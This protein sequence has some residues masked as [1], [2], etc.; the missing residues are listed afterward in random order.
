MR[1]LTFW[2]LGILAGTIF[3]IVMLFAPLLREMATRLAETMG[4][5][6]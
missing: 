4:P 2:R 5:F 3:C 6:P 1:A